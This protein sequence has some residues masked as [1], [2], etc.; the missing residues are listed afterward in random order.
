MGA[1]VKANNLDNLTAATSWVGG[2]V[3]TNA[4]AAKWDSTFTINGASVGTTGNA[5]FGNIWVASDAVAS[6]V[7]D[8]SISGTSSVQSYGR[9]GNGVPSDRSIYLAANKSITGNFT[10]IVVL[11]SSHDVEIGANSVL[12]P[13]NR[14]LGAI[15]GSATSGIVKYGAG[16]MW[17]NRASTAPGPLGIT[18]LTIREGTIV[19]ATNTVTNP[20]GTGSLT[21]N[22]TGSGNPT[23]QYSVFNG[24]TCSLPNV[25][26]MSTAGTID[27]PSGVTAT[28][29]GNSGG[30]AVTGGST[31]PLIKTGT[32]SLTFSA[33]AVGVPVTVSAGTLTST[34][35]VGVGSIGTI[36]V[37]G[38]LTMNGSASYNLLGATLTGSGTVNIGGGTIN[39][40][41]PS[42]TGTIN[43]NFVYGLAGQTRTMNGLTSGTVDTVSG[44]TVI[45]TDRTRTGSLNNLVASTVTV[46]GTFQGAGDG[47]VDV[48]NGTT[49][50]M[51][52]PNAAF[53]HKISVW[54]AGKLSLTNSASLPANNEVWV[55]FPTTAVAASDVLC[56]D[57]STCTI[58]GPWIC[59]NASS[60]GDIRI[61]S[62]GVLV[63]KQPV[64]NNVASRAIKI[65]ETS[66]AYTG[67]V[68]VD[69]GG[70]FPSSS[71]VSVSRGTLYLASTS[72]VAFTSGLTVNAAA[73]LACAS[74]GAYAAQIAGN[75]TLAANSILKFGAP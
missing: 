53:N 8:S 35:S 32:G 2:V 73:T 47:Y 9:T 54:G 65:N 37:D 20:I 28:F 68:R 72:S 13:D 24:A 25:I 15:S 30:F 17:F 66:S 27:V 42:F 3:P 64:N 12:K 39:C 44:A 34:G 19:M 16:E 29:T 43:G 1:V 55:D 61:S 41:A 63:L 50:I 40:D 33:A 69:T 52:G 58:N 31:T 14:I 75:V 21:F 36:T 6:I 56:D 38:T 60:A 51:D 10:L 74:A 71:L 46:R 49:L 18:F 59:G 67:V 22:D 70:S 26:S 4:N 5:P 48:Q 11:A 57:T 45:F 7:I 62:K 23:L